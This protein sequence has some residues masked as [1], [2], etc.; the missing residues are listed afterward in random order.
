MYESS[1]DRVLLFSKTFHGDIR[2]GQPL[3]IVEG[4]DAVDASSVDT[5]FLSHSY[6]SDTLKLS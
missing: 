2:V 4:I 3:F 5:D 6:F 1:K